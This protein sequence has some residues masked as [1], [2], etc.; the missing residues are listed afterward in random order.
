MNSCC[1]STFPSLRKKYENGNGWAKPGHVSISTV[2]TFID[3]SQPCT[4]IYHLDQDKW[5]T[6]YLLLGQ[7][8][9]HI[10]NRSF[11]TWNV[12]HY[13]CK[14]YWDH[15][16]I[17]ETILYQKPRYGWK[18]IVPSAGYNRKGYQT[19]LPSLPQIVIF[20]LEFPEQ[21]KWTGGGLGNSLHPSINLPSLLWC[22]LNLLC[23]SWLPASWRTWKKK[24][25]PLSSPSFNSWDVINKHGWWTSST[26]RLTGDIQKLIVITPTTICYGAKQFIHILLF[27]INNL[28]GGYDLL[29]YEMRK[30]RL[31][32]AKY[33]VQDNKANTLQWQN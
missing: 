1:P 30:M 12:I 17:L 26:E 23:Y 24:K 25:A 16:F 6:V 21:G 20:A 11:L 3:A 15:H 10:Q 33:C 4:Q 18:T 7:I 29:Y 19:T 2:L 8:H 28:S 14:L 5:W 32:L 31:K 22:Q 27:N 9:F 13:H